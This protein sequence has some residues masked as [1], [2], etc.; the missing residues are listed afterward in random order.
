MERA[1]FSA[2]R[3]N[4]QM[5]LC[6]YSC[7]LGGRSETAQMVRNVANVTSYKLSETI[8]WNSKWLKASATVWGNREHHQDL[9]EEFS[10]SV[11]DNNNWGWLLKAKAN[12]GRGW[13]ATANFQYTSGYRSMTYEFESMWP[14]AEA[15]VEKRFGHVTAYLN[16]SGLIDP[17]IRFSIYDEKGHTVYTSENRRNNRIVMLGLRFEL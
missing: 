15:S 13:S 2:A 9:G 12:M 6:Y 16:A 8:A 1:V 3:E 10:E 4:N 11:V 5:A 14:S 17:A 7:T